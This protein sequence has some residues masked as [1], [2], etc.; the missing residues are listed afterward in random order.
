[1]PLNRYP[2]SRSVTT[3]ASLVKEDGT[4][5]FWLGDTVWELFQRPTCEEVDLYLETRAAQQFTVVQAVVLGEVCGASA[6][7][8]EGHLPLKEQRPHSAERGLF[9]AR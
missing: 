8:A 9:R 5:F 4:P 6:S 7:N 3:G 1:M 2:V